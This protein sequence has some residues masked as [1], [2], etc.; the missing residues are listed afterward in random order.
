MFSHKVIENLG[1]SS[2]I[3]A[4]FE[5]GEALK[6]IYGPDQVYDFTLG[7]PDPEPPAEVMESMARLIQEP[8]IH[9]YM[10]NAGYTEARESVAS[11][12]K[13]ETGV[14]FSAAQVIMVSGAAG[15]LNVVLKAL[16]DPGDEV[17]V[18]APYFAEYKFYAE[19]HGGTL[20][21]VPSLPDTFQP[22]IP[23]IA[24]AITERTKAVLLN[25]PNNPSGAVYTETCLRALAE[26][27]KN[28]EA[29]FGHD[30]Y[31]LSDEPYVQ[32]VY[33]GMKVPPVAAIFDHS[34]VINSFSKSLA[35]P[36]ERIGYVAVNPKIA[37]ADILMA[38]LA[39]A[40]R[41]LGFVNAPSLFQ[42]VVAENLRIVAGLDSYRQRRD[43]LYEIVTEAGFECA[44]P[45]GAFYLFPKSPIPDDGKLANMALKHNLIIVGGT[46]FC[47]PGYFRLAYCVSMDT[48]LRS[49][50]AF[51]RLREDCARA[52]EGGPRQG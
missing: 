20:I 36:G 49:R 43:A 4:M 3:R 45:Q 24:Q 19:N 8:G 22:D 6:K 2:W 50:D 34:I 46:G 18:S 51:K 12:M 44:L 48:I 14:D 7:N 21:A 52:A 16:L 17:L 25:S 26:V 10:A 41:T 39:F 23:A 5:Q 28:A 40:N 42:K 13:D 47:Y 35:L 30:I 32:I 9:K 33:D 15:G 1:S 37:D 11:Y 31:V 38:A 29:R 27:L